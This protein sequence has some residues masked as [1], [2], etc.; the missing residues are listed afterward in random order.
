VG[1]VLSIS[2]ALTS[3]PLVFQRQLKDLRLLGPSYFYAGVVLLLG[4]SMIVPFL[5]HGILSPLEEI[6]LV[7][8]VIIDVVALSVIAPLSILM[9]LS[10]FIE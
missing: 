7:E 2:S 4:F 10:N 5:F 3:D 6:D 9:V 1:I 8:V